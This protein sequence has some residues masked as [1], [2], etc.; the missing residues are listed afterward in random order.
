MATNVFEPEVL[1]M[2][3]SSFRN[4][5]EAID[6]DMILDMEECSLDYRLWPENQLLDSCRYDMDSE[7][8]RALDT[9]V[10]EL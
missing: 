3:R 10:K 6:L 5:I 4:L 7:S 8:K 9:V 2:L 1:A